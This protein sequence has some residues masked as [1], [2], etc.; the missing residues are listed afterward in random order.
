MN[1]RGFS[2][3]NGVYTS[4]GVSSGRPVRGVRRGEGR[5]GAA[6]LALATAKRAL[7]A[8]RKLNDERELKIFENTF[9]NQLMGNDVTTQWASAQGAVIG[10]GGAVMPLVFMPQGVGGKQN[11]VGEQILVKMIE[12]RGHYT[13]DADIGC[14]ALRMIVFRDKRQR[15]SSRFPSRA[16]CFSCC[17]PTAC[18]SLTTPIVSRSTWTAPSRRR[19]PRFRAI[20][21]VLASI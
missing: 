5:K 11:R 8:T 14:S 4:T 19:R 13:T 12:L 1:A 10:N 21:L 6:A 17:A 2:S 16:K 15:G 9:V 18:L 7:Q 3:K 20:R